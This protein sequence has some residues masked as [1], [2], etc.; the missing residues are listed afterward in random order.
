MLVHFSFYY[1]SFLQQKKDKLAAAD[2]SNIAW[3]EITG[4]IQ[5]TSSILRD[6][7][8]KGLVTV[9]LGLFQTS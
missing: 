5:A 8:Q 3:T 7:K 1:T 6:W 2:L 9:E 4:K